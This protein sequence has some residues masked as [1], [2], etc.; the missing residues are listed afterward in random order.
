MERG[1]GGS[2][3]GG[4]QAGGPQ[5]R[6]PGAHGTA[7]VLRALAQ[8]AAEGRR[9]PSNRELCDRLGIA[10]EARVTQILAAL[11]GRR[12]IDIEWSGPEGGARRV[13]IRAS[14]LVTGWSRMG[15]AP[16][17][18]APAERA[19]AGPAAGPEDDDEPDPRILARE[20]MAALG[21]A[22]RRSAGRFTDVSRA[23]A[24][25]IAADTPA[26]PGLPEKPAPSSYMS[27]TLARAQPF[28]PDP[29]NDPFIERR[30]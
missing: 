10:R 14:G 4:S 7:R 20:G 24:A 18:W 5:E 8:A 28:P 19:P 12:L 16:A 6:G 3:A 22:L 27:S 17:E 11:R 26:D 15:P 1:Q 25:R 2:Q 13:A 30:Q 23:E 9:C 21:R 29:G